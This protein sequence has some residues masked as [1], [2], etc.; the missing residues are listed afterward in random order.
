MDPCL[1]NCNLLP[2]DVIP[3]AVNFPVKNLELKD[4]IPLST[5]KENER[6]RS[7]YDLIANIVHDGK[8]GEGSYRLQPSLL[9]RP[10]AS[11]SCVHGS[12]SLDAKAR[13]TSLKNAPTA[14]YSPRA[15]TSAL[16][17][18]QRRKEEPKHG[19]RHE[20]NG[21]RPRHQPR[22][23]KLVP[24]S[25]RLLDGDLNHQTQPVEEEEPRDLPRGRQ[26]P[27][28]VEYELVHNRRH[29]EGPHHGRERGPPAPHH[30]CRKRDDGF[31]HGGGRRMLVTI[32]FHR[33]PRSLGG[34]RRGR[35][36]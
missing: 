18:Q 4:Y 33:L 28:V 21:Q 11:S 12:R 9:L 27:Q 6:L 30:P 14:A 5:P 31:V 35:A 8:P 2:T 23:L 3:I 22:H 34:R 25:N 26:P 15:L 24:F 7:K 19:A 36:R 13:P 17:P 29:Y 16:H 32:M 20:R 1:I 10:V